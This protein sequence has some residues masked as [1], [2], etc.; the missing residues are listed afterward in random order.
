VFMNIAAAGSG[1]IR[2]AGAGGLAGSGGLAGP[3]GGL[4]G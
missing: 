2:L 3:H 4:V 1:T